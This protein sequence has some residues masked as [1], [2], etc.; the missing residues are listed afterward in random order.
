MTAK[1]NASRVDYGGAFASERRHR[2][3]SRSEL[4]C[5][6]R[7]MGWTSTTLDGSRKDDFDYIGYANIE[8]KY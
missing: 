6:E 4:A 1:P 3:D 5:M 8:R 7:A 2:S